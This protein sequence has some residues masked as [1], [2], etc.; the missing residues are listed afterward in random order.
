MLHFNILELFPIILV[1]EICG[2][3]MS[4]QR[5]LFLSDNKATVFVLKKCHQKILL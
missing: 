2:E 4:D 1:F 5:I 3:K